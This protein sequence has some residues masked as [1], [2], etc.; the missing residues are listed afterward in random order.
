MKSGW[1]LGVATAL[2]VPLAIVL[3]VPGWRV[4]VVGHLRGEPL[5]EG[6]PRSYWAWRLLADVDPEERRRAAELLASLGPGAAPAAPE[7]FQA[8]R[9]ED[10]S[11]RCQAALALRELGPDVPGLV[12]ALRTALKDDTWYVRGAAAEGPGRMGPRAAEALGALTEALRDPDASVRY[13]AAEAVMAIDPGSKG[14]EALMVAGGFR[15]HPRSGG[16]H[17][18]LARRGDDRA[19]GVALGRCRPAGLR[20][21]H[22][23]AHQPGELREG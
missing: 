12:S 3:S 18:P 17:A 23:P 21:A 14:A 10:D 5:V 19:S 6:M 1:K 2:L 8:A 4:T 11:V 7:L 15:P 20:L 13:Y 16:S 9:G 22:Q